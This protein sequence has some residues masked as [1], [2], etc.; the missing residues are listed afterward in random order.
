[1]KNILFHRSEG[2]NIPNAL[3]D[4]SLKTAKD[5]VRSVVI[6]TSYYGRFINQLL[7]IIII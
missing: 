1:M 2:N 7:L 4:I 6:Y 3:D 5:R